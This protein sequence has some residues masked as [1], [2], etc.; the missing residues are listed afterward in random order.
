MLIQPNYKDPN[1]KTRVILQLALKHREHQISSGG[2][3][4]FDSLT[5]DEKLKLYTDDLEKRQKEFTT[6]SQKKISHV[7]N[8]PNRSMNYMKNSDHL[9]MILN[10]DKDFGVHDKIILATDQEQ[11]NIYVQKGQ[12]V[13]I[14]TFPNN[15]GQSQKMKILPRQMLNIQK[16]EEKTLNKKASTKRF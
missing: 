8:D 7:C 12:E 9:K 10:Y 13:E 15:I 14:Y 1:V 11:S 3:I 16:D 5:E 6:T 4:D 2:K